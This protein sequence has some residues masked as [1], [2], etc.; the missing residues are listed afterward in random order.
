MTT[1]FSLSNGAIY[2]VSSLRLK[3]LTIFQEKNLCPSGNSLGNFA[4]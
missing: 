3:S 4:V 1:D 2:V